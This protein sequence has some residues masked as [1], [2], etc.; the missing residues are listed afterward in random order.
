MQTVEDFQL[1]IRNMRK[2][3]GQAPRA[4]GA[5]RFDSNN[6]C[7]VHCAYCHNARS[8]DL[9]DLC[10]FQ[11]FLEQSVLSVDEFQFGCAMEPTLD[12]RLCD[13]MEV[14][15]RT[16]VRPKSRFR[17]QTN[18]I[19]LHRHD[20]AR[21][22]AAGLTHLAVSV[23]SAEADTHKDLRG[24]TSL[25]K[26]ER[27]LRNFHRD[28]PRVHILF[29]TTVTS[30]NIDALP[31]LVSWGIALG[32]EQF[33]FRQMFHYEHSPVVDHERM[34]AL[35]VSGDAFAEARARIQGNFGGSARLIFI[36]N[37]TLVERASRVRVDSGI[38]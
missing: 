8:D 3:L 16:G 20:P 36:E 11:S 14:L 19:L 7:N 27:N 28:C 17:L 30:A 35:T 24:G 12:D 10:D 38:A 37:S 34:R 22:V 18:G 32:V 1:N 23:D 9:I 6:D 13:F 26:V 29:L 15:G 33:V 21:M 31:T 2:V 25:A 5:V 4:F